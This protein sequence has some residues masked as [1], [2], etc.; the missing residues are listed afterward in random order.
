MLGINFLKGIRPYR[1]PFEIFLTNSELLGFFVSREMR[2]K[3]L[4]AEVP[5]E[6]L[7]ESWIFSAGN[8]GKNSV[9]IKRTPELQKPTYKFKGEFR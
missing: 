3:G 8:S 2:E 5:F 4:F 9:A 7:T 6:I 1:D